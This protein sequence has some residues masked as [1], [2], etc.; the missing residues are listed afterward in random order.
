MKKLL[1][2]SVNRR[3]FLKRLG[4]GAVLGPFPRDHILWAA[5]PVDVQPRPPLPRGYLLVQDVS[6]YNKSKFGAIS[7][8]EEAR[9]LFGQ[10][11]GRVDAVE[12]S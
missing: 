8:T 12:F 6:T 3:L 2:N 5:A 7:T 9:R 11:A 10:I 4:M 1:G